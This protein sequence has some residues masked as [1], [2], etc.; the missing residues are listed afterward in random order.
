MYNKARLQICQYDTQALL[1]FKTATSKITQHDSLCV[2]P[3]QTMSMK[4]YMP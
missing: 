4:P 2:L 3:I 1:I